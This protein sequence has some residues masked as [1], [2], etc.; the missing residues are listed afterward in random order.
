M[1]EGAWAESQQTELTSHT[2]LKVKVLGRM[3]AEWS[4]SKVSI[5]K[6]LLFLPL[7]ARSIRSRLKPGHTFSGGTKTEE[8]DQ[9]KMYLLYLKILGSTNPSQ[10]PDVL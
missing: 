5:L 1:Y 2:Q 6:R 7:V 8:T 9:E 3:F 4:L 10:S